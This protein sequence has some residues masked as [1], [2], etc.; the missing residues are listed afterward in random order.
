MQELSVGAGILSSAG[1]AFLLG[2][3][4]LLETF[5]VEAENCGTERVT[6]RLKPRQDAPY[7]QIGLDVASDS[8]MVVATAVKDLFGNITELEFA[9]LQ[10]NLEP[11]PEL[12]RFEAPEGTRVLRMDPGSP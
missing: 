11:D 10:T 2:D 12:F 5:A 4:N 7:E 3:G 6:L 1:L 9:N 8:G